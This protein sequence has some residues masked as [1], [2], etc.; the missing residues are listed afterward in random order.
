MADL[1]LH[2]GATNVSREDLEALPMPIASSDKHLPLAHIDLTKS[3]EK[4]L[5]GMDIGIKRQVFGLSPAPTF[6]RCFAAWDLDMPSSFEQD[7]PGEGTSLVWGQGNDGKGPSLQIGG[8][9]HTFCCDNLAMTGD[10]FLVKAKHLKSLALMPF[11][12]EALEG[13]VSD[14]EI[15]MRLQEQAAARTLTHVEAEAWLEIAFGQ[16][17]LPRSVKGTVN[18]AFFDKPENSGVVGDSLWDLSQAGTFGLRDLPMQTRMP[19]TIQ[20]GRL[21]RQAVKL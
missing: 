11:L 12:E 9:H 19:A 3:L 8:G 5:A 10:L 16:K 4:I 1:M 14:R 21:I 18:Q 13:F 20:W 15:A 17:V 6:A 7:R 2:C